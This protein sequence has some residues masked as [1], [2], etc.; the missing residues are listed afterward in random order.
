MSVIHTQAGAARQETVVEIFII[1]RD[2][3]DESRRHP[4]YICKTKHPSYQCATFQVARVY[5]EHAKVACI[6]GGRVHTSWLLLR[7]LSSGSTLTG[8]CKVYQIFRSAGGDD[9]WSW[10]CHSV[11]VVG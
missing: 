2:G 4:T 9:F 10:S 3:L 8:S 6:N 1:E 11:A 5:L 7:S